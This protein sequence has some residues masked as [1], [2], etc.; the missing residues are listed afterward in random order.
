MADALNAALPNAVGPSW[1]TGLLALVM[2]DQVPA[3]RRSEAVEA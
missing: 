2:R 1:R 3:E